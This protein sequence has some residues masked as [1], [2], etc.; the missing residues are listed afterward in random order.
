M[1]GKLGAKIATEFGI[2]VSAI[3]SFTVSMDIGTVTKKE[4]S[5]KTLNSLLSDTAVNLDLEFVQY[6]LSRKRKSLCV[7]YETVTTRGDLDLNADSQVEGTVHKM[8]N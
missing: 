8:I 4:A 5:W 3:D 7:V 2:D 1:N 6:V